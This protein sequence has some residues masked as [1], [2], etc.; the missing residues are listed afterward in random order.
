MKEQ[1]QEKEHLDGYRKLRT[2]SKNFILSTVI[3]ALTAESAMR[4]APHSPGQRR[5]TPQDTR[6]TG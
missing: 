6:Y 3:T 5:W 1:Q 4:T 2:E